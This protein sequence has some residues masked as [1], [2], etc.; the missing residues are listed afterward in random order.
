[1]S[2]DDRNECR[3]G[4][5]RLDRAYRYELCIGLTFERI[6]RKVNDL[7]ALFESAGQSWD[8]TAYRMLMRTL[9]L[10]NRENYEEVARRVPFA[11]ICREGPAV[12]VIEALLL[13]TA[14]LLENCRDDAYS[15]E[16][17]STFDHLKNKYGIQPLDPRCWRFSGRPAN[18]P[19]LRLAQIA[20]LLSRTDH[21]N[22]RLLA[23]RTREEVERLF[24]TDAS[25]YWSSYYNP[26]ATADHS[27]KR[28]GSQKACSMG[29]NLVSVLQILY[30]RLQGREETFNSRAF[31]LLESLPAEENRYTKF[32]EYE[33][34][35]ITNALESQAL[36]QLS[37]E[38]CD[39]G[40]CRECPLKA[41][42][43]KHARANG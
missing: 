14:G 18:H 3:S 10:S 21:L 35:R 1:M 17:R 32:W 36:L 43:C 30:G 27:T 24:C 15:A 31:E 25:Q 2:A 26:S 13:G 29:I 33:G 22:D 42:L 11:V 28:L 7:H 19:R 34:I 8:Q 20:T 5:T 39:R 23:C 12:P 6:V 37:R 4:L 38:Y 9:D 40:R 41:L 16:L